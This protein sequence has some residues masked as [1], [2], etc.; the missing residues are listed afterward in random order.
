MQWLYSD[1]LKIFTLQSQ[2]ISAGRN[3]NQLR[4]RDVI[5]LSLTT[6]ASTDFASLV[7]LFA[8]VIETLRLEHE[9]DYVLSTFWARPEHV[10]STFWARAPRKFSPYKSKARVQCGKFVLVIVLLLQAEGRQWFRQRNSILGGLIASNWK[11]VHLWNEKSPGACG[12][13]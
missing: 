6:P 3:E 7:C 1:W 9:D 2:P 5:F 12:W 13:V 11:R 10:L 4:S 8:S